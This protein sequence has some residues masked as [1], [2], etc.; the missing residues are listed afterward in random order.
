[1]LF[2]LHAFLIFITFVHSQTNVIFNIPNTSPATGS[3]TSISV[4]FL[5][6]TPNA[7][8]TTSITNAD[9]QIVDL[10]AINQ[11][12]AASVWYIPST[13]LAGS[14]RVRLDVINSLPSVNG[15]YFAPVNITV[16]KSPSLS[17]CPNDGFRPQSL[18]SYS[19]IQVTSPQ[20]GALI[21]LPPPG[22]NK[23]GQ[24]T[25]AYVWKV[26]SLESGWQGAS[27]VVID[28]LAIKDASVPGTNQVPTA[29]IAQTS[30]VPPTV[31]AKTV[32][33]SLPTSISEQVMGPAV[34]RMNY[35]VGGITKFSF[36]ETFYVGRSCN[37]TL[38][39]TGATT[40][41]IIG[42]T[43]ITP[44]IVIKTPEIPSLNFTPLIIGV[45][46]GTVVVTVVAVLGILWVCRRRRR[47][48]KRANKNGDV[49]SKSDM[50]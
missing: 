18:T 36:S 9:G 12:T 42:K 39:Q 21:S 22:F 6:P 47:L 37:G 24:V 8:F 3:S 17:S 14:Y 5:D 38:L 15:Q 1:M 7:K 10:V 29:T 26:D 40:T 41:N 13:F 16:T 20:A 34:V 49:T 48:G 46:A 44:T 27:S 23:A 35:T 25:V 45:V 2:Q 11:T 28:L 33:L 4:I 32:P 30:V 19:E 43:T 31:S 50:T